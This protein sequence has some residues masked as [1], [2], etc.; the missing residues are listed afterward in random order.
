MRGGQHEFATRNV[1]KD[2]TRGC[3]WPGAN[4][5]A[6]GLCRDTG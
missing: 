6:S 1:A 4:D 3:R 5:G 2:N